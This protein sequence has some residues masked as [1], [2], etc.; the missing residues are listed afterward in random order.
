MP[1]ALSFLPHYPHPYP[2]APH[3]LSLPPGTDG[4]RNSLV[5]LAPGGTLAVLAS[6]PVA[7]V[8]EFSV[9]SSSF[10]LFLRYAIASSNIVIIYSAFLISFSFSLAISLSL[11]SSKLVCSING[12]K[13]E[14]LMIHP[15]CFSFCDLRVK[16]DGT[17]I[18]AS[19]VTRAR[20][21]PCGN[22]HMLPTRACSYINNAYANT[23][24][25]PASYSNSLRF[26]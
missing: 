5:A 20:G 18:S 6:P 26:K 8:P 7:P 14:A 9:F 15:L 11:T 13:D 24:L 1:F 21:Q 23:S 16:P 3:P 17:C 2:S 25:H 22:T 12:G 10:L 19:V 4:T